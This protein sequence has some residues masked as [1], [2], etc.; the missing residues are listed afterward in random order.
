MEEEDKPDPCGLCGEPFGV[1]FGRSLTLSKDKEMGFR[2]ESD[3]GHDRDISSGRN[4]ALG[5]DK[6]VSFGKNLT[7]GY[8]RE[9]G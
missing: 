4:L 2:Q 7:L 6:K 3:V 1:L 5:H 8:N 9:V